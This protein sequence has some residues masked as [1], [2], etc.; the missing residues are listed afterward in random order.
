MNRKRIFFNCG[1]RTYGHW[2]LIPTISIHDYDNQFDI[3]IQFLSLCF[4]IAI[5]KKFYDR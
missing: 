3:W 2:Y 1:Y 4:E 5:M